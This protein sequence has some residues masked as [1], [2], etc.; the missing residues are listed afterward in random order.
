MLGP[1]EVCS[2]G[3]R[4][5]MGGV[6]Q[7][8]ILALLI[9]NRGRAVSADRIVDEIYGE[10]AAGGVRRSVQSIVSLLRRD[11]GDAIVGTGDGYVFD[12]P[13]KAVDAC[14]FDDR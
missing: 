11:L 3:S 9:A 2:A 1:I 10:D 13:R 6:K 4:V 12:A 8:S 7:R 5:R 14:L